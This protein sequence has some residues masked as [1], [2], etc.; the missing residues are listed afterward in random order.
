[1]QRLP[2]D[3]PTDPSQV[4]AILTALRA[5][6]LVVLPTETVYGLAADAHNAKAVELLRTVKGRQQDQAFTHHLAKSEDLEALAAPLPARFRRFLN[7]VW[8]GPVTAIVPAKNGEDS[9]GL[10]VPDHPLTGQVIEALG[11]SLFMTSV[12]HHGEPP[13]NDPDTIAATFGEEPAIAILADAGAPQLGEPSVVI[14]LDGR[15]LDILRTGPFTD[16]ELQT[17]AATKVLFVCTGNTCRSPLAQ[18][19][20]QQQA[21]KILGIEPAEVLAHGLAFGSAGTSTLQGMPASS[22][23]VA[24]GAEIGIDLSDHSSTNLTPELVAEA[25]Y[26][27]CLSES[28]RISI[29]DIMPEVEAKT[30]LIDPSGK[31]VTD[32]FGGDLETYRLTRTAL[33]DLIGQHI[34]ALIAGSAK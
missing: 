16:L 6:Q 1:M 33:E 31:D 3:N 2:I 20:A 8:P 4:D 17:D 11:G 7:R 12:N 14:R 18:A 29:V 27:F 10:R 30:V 26:I 5:G 34:E 9:I 28:H 19:I 13:L 24:A 23:S 15:R 32:P 21:A 22:G 25:D